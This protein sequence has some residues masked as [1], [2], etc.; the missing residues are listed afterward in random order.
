MR[1]ETFASAILES[2]LLTKKEILEAL[3]PPIPTETHTYNCTVCALQTH[4]QQKAIRH[5]IKHGHLVLH[6]EKGWFL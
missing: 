5:T 4:D 6:V 1:I 2:G 3:C